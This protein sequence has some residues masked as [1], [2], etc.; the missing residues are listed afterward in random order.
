MKILIFII[1][2]SLFSV[3]LSNGQNYW[4]HL[5]GPYGGTV[6]EMKKL[7]N[8]NLAALRN[9]GLYISTD[10]G[11]EWIRSE[12]GSVNSNLCMDVS[13]SGTVYLGKSTGGLWWT[14]NSGQSWNF[15]P[16][17]IAPH[18][19]LWA[20]VI[21]VRVSP[22]G[23]ILINNHISFNGGNNFNAFT[24]NGTSLLSRDYA[25]NSSGNIF[26][27]TQNGIFFSTDNASSW[28]NINGNL[29]SLNVS[30]VLTDGGNLIAALPGSG[31]FKTTNN[32]LSWTE[33]NNGVTDLNFSKLY[34]DVQ[35][36][37]FAGTSEGRIFKST[38]QGN[39]W[40]QIFESHSENR[41]NS[42]YSGGSSVFLISSLGIYFSDNN[43]I[44]W[45]EKNKN[46]T[47]PVF[48]SLTSPD[49]NS[50]M[51]AS[52]TGIHYSSDNGLSWVRRNGDLPSVF[53]NILHR[54]HNGEIITGLRNHGIFRTA[55][56]GLT[57]NLSNNGIESG[58]NINSISNSPGG[59]I[60]ALS[61]HP[62]FSDSVKLYRSS[63]NGNNWIKIFQP[64]SNFFNLLKTDAD[65][66]IYLASL[67]S[68]PTRLLVSTDYGNSWTERTLEQF[69]FPDNFKVSGNDLYL[70]SD[71]QIHKSSDAG[72]TWSIIQD[73]GW[74]GSG[75][76]AMEVN[77]Q[78][79][80][81]VSLNGSIYETT[82]NGNTWNIHNTGLTP[83]AL[84][85]SFIFDNADYLYGLTYNNGIFK[86]ADP[87]ITNAPSNSSIIADRYMLSQNFP[88]PF[89]PVTK[90]KYTIPVSGNVK[91]KIYNSLGREV[92][93]LV[94]QFQTSGE[95]ETEFNSVT[96][97]TELA[98][99]VYFYTL[100]SGNFRQSRTMI[101]IK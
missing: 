43:G 101:L 56:N 4:R 48:N 31:I 62:N 46:L 92:A 41:I 94:N 20:T 67:R 28:T 8:G 93:T 76:S 66:K 69:F 6:L 54:C 29:P 61:A 21:I 99:G 44:S 58:S 36:N 9:D 17:S 88:N 80:I 57:W 13:N 70:I 24:Y 47:V 40:T 37:Y 59:N 30:G 100:E 71:G 90:I 74:S 65:G 81:F 10:N 52:G 3:S 51:T 60:F 89:N 82:D 32:G 64:E 55:D 12:Q 5:S 97:G 38:D 15:N 27:A 7:P 14:A 39:S 91:M 34:K 2:L 11:E 79:D 78:G 35:N 16:I 86:S 84:I 45:S 22:Q 96:A 77:R 1:T 23:L 73:G 33:I 98:G 26:S 72:I 53:S 49:V 25:F 83:G 87:I 63:D 95:Y 19:G 68:F 75:I 85:N 42:I 18:S 50:I